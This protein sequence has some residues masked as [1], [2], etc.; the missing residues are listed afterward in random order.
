[1]VGKITPWNIFNAMNTR[2]VM[3]HMFQTEMI[4]WTTRHNIKA[5]PIGVVGKITPWNFPNAMITRKVMC[6][7]LNSNDSYDNKTQ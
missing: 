3:C 4:P 1:M 5:N 7:V 2:K 6:H